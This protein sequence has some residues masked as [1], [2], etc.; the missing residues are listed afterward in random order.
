MYWIQSLPVF[1]E[2][3]M[4]ASMFLPNTFVTAIWYFFWVGWHRSIRRPYWRRTGHFHRSSLWGSNDTCDVYGNGT[5]HQTRVQPLD[6]LH[7]LGFALLPTVLLP[8]DPGVSQL[9]HHLWGHDHIR[10]PSHTAHI[11]SC[12][13][14]A[15]LMTLKSVPASACTRCLLAVPDYRTWRLRDRCSAELLLR[16]DVVCADQ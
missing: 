2:S 4:M 8:V 5:H 11:I 15:E 1:S 12:R 13:V 14:Q 16:R 9:L 6:A 3:T 10:P 7:D